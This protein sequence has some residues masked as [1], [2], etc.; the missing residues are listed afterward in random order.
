MR[1]FAGPQL[2]SSTST[3]TSCS[4]DS[5]VARPTPRLR[6]INRP[7][8][9]PAAEGRIED[10]IYVIQLSLPGV[11]PKDVKVSLMDSVLTIKG[12]RTADHDTT[13]RD[14]FVREL[15]YGTFER[16]FQLPRGRRCGPGRSQA[17]E[18]HAGGEGSRAASRH[19]EDDRSHGWLEREAEPK[20]R[21]CRCRPV[22]P[23]PLYG[24]SSVGFA[25]GHPT[26]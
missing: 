23:R 18:R 6:P 25:R 9:L 3:M 21:P 4:T 26:S 11:D 10:G 8:W 12:E 2:G 13:G 5:S 7:S 17:R 20:P 1:S 24:M 16:S 15:A 22:R 14:Y 19:A